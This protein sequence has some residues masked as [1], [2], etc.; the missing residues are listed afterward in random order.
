MFIL[1][2]SHILSAIL[3]FRFLG[4]QVNRAKDDQFSS[5]LNY[6]WLGPN[7]RKS[8]TTTTLDIYQ[9]NSKLD[10]DIELGDFN[11]LLIAFNGCSYF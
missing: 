9:K 7:L 4:N 8:K 11:A 2:G 3:G 5:M 1:S 10:S 6:A